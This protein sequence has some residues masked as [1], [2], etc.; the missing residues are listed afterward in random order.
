[1]RATRARVAVFSRLNNEE[2]GVPDLL[3]FELAEPATSDYYIMFNGSVVRKAYV[4]AI[5]FFE[6]FKDQSALIGEI[7]NVGV[8][9]FDFLGYNGFVIEEKQ[10][11]DELYAYMLSKQKQGAMV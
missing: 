5:K 6:A 7:R 1:M 2:S 4:D 10:K 11:I 9:E 3:V 8:A